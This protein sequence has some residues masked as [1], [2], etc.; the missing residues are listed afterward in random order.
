M[1]AYKYTRS[2]RIASD[3]T[4]LKSILQYGNSAYFWYNGQ[5]T[6]EKYL[7][8]VSDQ[9]ITDSW[10]IIPEEALVFKKWDQVLT[11]NR[12]GIDWYG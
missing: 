12:R 9:T 11:S 7:N 10:Y 1:P 5:N 6:C 2:Y 4:V 3:K 8:S